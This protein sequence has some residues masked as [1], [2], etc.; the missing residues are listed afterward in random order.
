ME[1]WPISVWNIQ[2]GIPKT[3]CDTLR[4][5]LSAKPGFMWEGRGIEEVVRCSHMTENRNK[6]RA[7][8]NSHELYVSVN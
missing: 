6:C 3:L 4:A 1:A 8:V 2:F 7:L 5:R